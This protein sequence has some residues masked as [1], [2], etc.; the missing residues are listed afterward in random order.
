MASVVVAARNAHLFADRYAFIAQMINEWR[1]TC[2]HHTSTLS[3]TF[4]LVLIGASRYKMGTR[5]EA[6]LLFLALIVFK[7]RLGASTLLYPRDSETREQKSL[8]GVWHFRVP[9]AADGNA[10]FHENWFASSFQEVSKNEK[11]SRR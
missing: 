11:D 6:A 3:A 1:G 5:A 2:M 8:D 9:H 4:G 7:T 10:A